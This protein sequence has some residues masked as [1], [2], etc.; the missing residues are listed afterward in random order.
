MQKY[1]PLFQLGSAIASPLTETGTK[2][3]PVTVY[4]HC[5]YHSLLTLHVPAEQHV[6]PEYPLP[7]H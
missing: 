1:W 2:R 3:N 6:G 7:P 4:T 5:E